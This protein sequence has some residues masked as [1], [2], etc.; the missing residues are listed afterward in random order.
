MG[1]IYPINVYCTRWPTNAN[2]LN[3]YKNFQNE[4]EHLKFTNEFEK[5]ADK[6]QKYGNKF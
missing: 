1:K 5:I 4:N 2:K 6:K 3:F